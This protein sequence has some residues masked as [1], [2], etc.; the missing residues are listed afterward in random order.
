YRGTLLEKVFVDFSVYNTWYSNFIGFQ[1]GIKAQFDSTGNVFYRSIQ[2]YRYSANSESRVITRGL[3]IGANYYFY[4]THAFNA[5][6][7]FNKLAVA[8]ENDPIIPAFNTPLH[9]FNI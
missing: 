7:S 1:I 6:Y 4:K 2:P 5:N 3:N 8:D 9:K